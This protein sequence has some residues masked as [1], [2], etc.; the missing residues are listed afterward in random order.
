VDDG[1]TGKDNKIL[2]FRF[3]RNILEEKNLLL[4]QNIPA[5]A[6]VNSSI[7]QNFVLNNDQKVTN[8]DIEGK[9]IDIYLE[10]QKSSP[11]SIDEL[12][13][14]NI[15]NSSGQRFKVSEIGSIEETAQKS[16]I[17]RV[18]GQTIGV[19]KAKLDNEYTNDQAIASR[20]GTALIE[21]YQADD[22]KLLK[23]LE[24]NKDSLEI[25]SEGDT[26]GFLKSFSELSIALLLA[27]F[28]SYIVLALFFNSFTQ[29]LV[30][31]YTIPLT[32]IGIMPAL[33]HLSNG[34]F[35]FLEIIGMIILVGI[36][37]NVAIFLIDSAN[38]RIE[39]GE[40]PV[41]AI[42]ISSGIRLK[43]VLM[44]KFTAIASL[45][46]LAWLS[47]IYRPISLVI[48]FGLLSS[49]FISL[50]T[51][52]ILFTFFRWSSKNFH[53]LNWFLKLTFYPMMPIYWLYWDYKKK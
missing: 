10:D 42:T 4:G 19:I 16:N 28:S 52:P 37:E 53:D 3:D 22:A 48:M 46:P 32:F 17:Q 43:P 12:N 15:F 11:K 31:L 50:I 45:A 25:Y 20:I 44:T 8:I 9:D 36:V 24:L 5:T 35:G 1:F 51:T 29:P 7:K 26:A 23:E 14:I 21:Q 40:D 49:G 30:I 47:E 2:D 6:L 33:A 39:E 38:Q 41:K 34:Q 13:N 18:K 27:I